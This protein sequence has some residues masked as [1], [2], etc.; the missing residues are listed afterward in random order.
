[1]IR[2]VTPANLLGT[3]A[4]CVPTGVANGFPTGAQ[5][6]GDLFR[7]DL[8]LDA[9]PRRLKRAWECSR[10][11]I[12]G[13]DGR[14]RSFAKARGLEAAL[15]ILV[16]IASVRTARIRSNSTRTGKPPQE[17]RRRHGDVLVAEA[18]GEVI[19]VCQ[20][21]IFPHFQHTGGLL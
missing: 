21:M 1:M 12:P 8:C 16:G 9:P 2:F 13:P 11:S 3:A 6:I 7:E 15:P 17:T 10:P 4:A 18:S 19:G 14:R 20:V 5:I